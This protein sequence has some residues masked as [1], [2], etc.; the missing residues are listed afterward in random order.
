MVHLRVD[1][2]ASIL[3]ALDHM[4]FP[5]RTMPIEQIAVQPG[6]QLQQLAHPSRRR[7]GGPP[8]VVA[9]VDVVVR[10][11]PEVRECAVKRHGTLTKYRCHVAALQHRLVGV[12]DKGGSRV[13]GR[14]EQLQ[15]A[16]V[17]RMLA[18]LGRQEQ[19]VER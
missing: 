4:C 11:P 13:G 5:E 17:Q 15:C 1:R 10:R 3:E 2:E 18:R 9:E 8:Y 6:G 19:R 7:Q 16:D 12:A 14:G